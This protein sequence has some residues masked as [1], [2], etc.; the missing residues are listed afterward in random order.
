MEQKIITIG[1]SPCWDRTIEI[2][3]INWGQ[4]KI[5][6]AQKIVPAGKALN[7]N[8]ALAQMGRKSIIAGLWGGDDWYEMKK[9]TADLKNFVQI[10]LTKA[11]GKTRENITVIDTAN[12]RQIHLR[13]KSNLVNEKSLSDL[14]RNLKEIITKDSICIFTGAMPEKKLLDRTISLIETAKKKRAKIVVDISG[15]AL[16]KIVAKGGLFVI[17]PNVGEL[18]EIVGRRIPNQKSAIIVAAKKLL[19]KTMFVLVSRAEK[20]AILIGRD[21]L[22]SARYAGR[23]YD[24]YNTVGCGDFLLA[25]F[26]NE[27]CKTGNLKAALEKG[28][29]AATQK[30]FSRKG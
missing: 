30:A 21:V 16:K 18:G 15:A 14:N 17:K 6:S 19:E 3:D 11:K 13:S 1:L 29:E 10:R 20:G 27:F 24:V 4:H 7:I 12:K 25:G 2:K 5:I 8:K 26:I 28:L 23:K 9:A 22:L